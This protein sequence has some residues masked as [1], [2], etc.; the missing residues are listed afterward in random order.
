MAN[1]LALDTST[2]ACSVAL[3]YNGELLEDFRIIPRQHTKQLLPMVE[4]I[5][6][7]AGISVAQLDAIAFGRGRDHCRY[8][9]C[10][11][12][13]TGAGVCG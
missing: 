11:R 4:E 13:S 9:Y 7:E 2:D 12:C 8:P 1:I 6:T 10:H 3:S 5:L